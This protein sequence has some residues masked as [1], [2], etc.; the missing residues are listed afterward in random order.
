MGFPGISDHTPWVSPCAFHLW[1][2]LTHTLMP[3]SGAPTH[4]L[5]FL[6]HFTVCVAHH[7]ACYYNIG[8]ICYYYSYSQVKKP[9]LRKVHW[10]GV[11]EGEGQSGL[12]AGHV[13]PRL[14]IASLYKSVFN[15]HSTNPIRWLPVTTTV[16]RPCAVCFHLSAHLLL[17]QLHE[18]CKYQESSSDLQLMTGLKQAFLFS[19]C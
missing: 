7:R 3:G 1:N 4:I 10:T 2:R 12:N 5:L 17:K 16:C 15:N 13:I 6:E 19:P 9:S 18:I 8:K 11:T 14:G